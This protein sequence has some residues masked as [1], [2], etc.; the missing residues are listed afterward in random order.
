M[1][2]HLVVEFLLH[3]AGSFRGPFTQT[4]HVL[5]H[6]EI[7]HCFFQL[8]LLMPVHV[9]LPLF[10]ALLKQEPPGFYRKEDLPT[11]GGLPLQVVS[12]IFFFNY[13]SSILFPS[14]RKLLNSLP[15]SDD[16]PSNL[17]VLPRS[18]R[19]IF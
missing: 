12:A 11:F 13:H 1:V 14:S 16:C 18:S 5:Q 2:R 8:L 9:L 17:L 15:S 7:S 10:S 19:N 3:H 4:I 6:K